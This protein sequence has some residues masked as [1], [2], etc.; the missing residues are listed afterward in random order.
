ARGKHQTLIE[1]LDRADTA[2]ATSQL[3]AGRAALARARGAVKDY[4]EAKEFVGNELPAAGR[5]REQ[6][7]SLLQTAN[8]HRAALEKEFLPSLWREADDMLG[9]GRAKLETVAARLAE[10][11]QAADR[12]SPRYL[13]ARR[14]LEALQATFH[15]T[16]TLLAGVGVLLA[17]LRQLRSACQER[18]E[19]LRTARTNVE[20][21]FA[22]HDAIV[23][24]GART[25]LAQAVQADDEA[26]RQTAQP[27][28]DWTQIAPAWAAVETLLGQAQDLADSD[29]AQH[30]E[31]H[32]LTAALQTYAA[33][34]G[35]TLEANT[36]DRPRANQRFQTARRL[37][38][39]ASARL[40]DRQG[41]WRRLLDELNEAQEGLAK[42][43]QWAQEDVRLAQQATAEIDEAESA[44]R[45]V[46]SFYRLGV[47]ADA[48]S[49]G[50]L[51]DE[52]RKARANQDYE[53]AVQLANEAEQVAR[54]AENAALRAAEERERQQERE[55]QLRQAAAA[56][57]VLANAGSMR[58]ALGG[59]FSHHRGSLSGG[60]M[61]SGGARS[62]SG[63]S[64]SSSSSGTSD[65]RI[66]TG[67]SQTGW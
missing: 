60:G 19:T 32:K 59:S 3:E 48:S 53:R 56:A 15:E 1:M 33:K 26:R 46:Q 63:S 62:S 30:A 49:V 52:A 9:Q 27:R 36:A 57:A 8:E 39:A 25:A 13:L 38:D 28:P 29:V 54:Q 34:V 10:A 55:R 40:Q 50:R 18:A 45:R 11:A 51:L 5:R 24:S 42:A 44:A 31:A 12:K 20:R 64:R 23:R 47:R 7:E 14:T 61:S 22:Q 17:R 41:D 4:A 37:I 35:R 2:G 58:D 67:T 16:Q 65:T 66:P 43:E 21:Y 6:L